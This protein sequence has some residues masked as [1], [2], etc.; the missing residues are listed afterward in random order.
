MLTPKQLQTYEFI[1][2][3]IAKN[4]YAPTEAQIAEGIGISSRGV[5]HRY[6]KAL[7]EAGYIDIKRG[8]RRNIIL[9]CDTRYCLPVVGKIAAGAPIEAILSDQQF[10]FVDKFM[11]EDRFILEVQ[12]DSMIGDNIVH[13]DMIVCERTDNPSKNDIV[14]ALI[15]GEEATLKRV[16]QLD[17]ENVTLIPSNPNMQPMVFPAHRVAIQGRFLGLLRLS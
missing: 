2:E 1:K 4:D 14:V 11:G 12:G 5:A 8:K 9:K 10:N 16:A 17:D 13:G 3:F 15:D 7:Y 6:V